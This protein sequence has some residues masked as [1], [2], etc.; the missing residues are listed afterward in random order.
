MTVT[1]EGRDDAGPRS[2]P[3]G[4]MSGGRALAEMLRISGA[5]PMFGM[6]GF[7]LLPYYEAV[8]VLGMEHHLV[9]DERIGA[10][11]ADAYA[12]LT[13]RPGICDGTL[14]PGATNLVTGLVESLNAGVPVIALTGNTHRG[15][16]WKN[17]TQEARQVEI[18]RPAVKELIRVEAVE[19]IP[20]LVRRAFSVATSGRP[21]PV[22]LDVPEDVAHAEH[23]FAAEDFFA[24]PAT[25]RVPARRPRPDASEVE[26]A[27]ALLA[28]ARRPLILA[29][30]GV[31]LSGAHDA[32]LRLAEGAGIPVA[33]TLSGKGAIPC[34]HDL[35]VGL[36]GRY[37]RYANELIESSDCLLVVGCKLGEI[38]TKRYALPRPGTPLIHLDIVAE[39][40][41]RWAPTQVGLFG[42]AHSGLSDLATALESAKPP[43]GRR[44]CASCANAAPPGTPKRAPGTRATRS[45][46]TWAAWS[47]R[48]TG[49]SPR[50][51]CSSPTAVSPATGRASCTTPGARDADSSPTAVSPRSATA[52]RGRS[53]PPWPSG[54]SAAAP[55]RW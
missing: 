23:V 32:L 24:D 43:T 13:G 20:E 19:R 42:D 30:G 34:V 6:A 28:Q 27:A 21:G 8:R 9:N 12:R 45:R 3:G 25:A 44:T 50:T 40:I 39:E 55:P 5:G 2:S 49:H 54:P 17:M 15:H 52:C 48:S 26:R 53:A 31:H 10:F 1:T 51:G 14:G 36:F 38:A 4:P 18:L 41:G 35:S 47:A 16:S 22:V 7:Q 11:A 29:G 33:H 46:S 37:S